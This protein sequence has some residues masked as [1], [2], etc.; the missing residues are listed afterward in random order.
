M[1]CILGS[2]Q[3]LLPKETGSKASGRLCPYSRELELQNHERVLE[4]L[5]VQP[6]QVTESGFL[7]SVVFYSQRYKAVWRPGKP[8][9]FDTKLFFLFKNPPSS[10]EKREPSCTVGGNVN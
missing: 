5:D 6:E 3:S 9:R 2:S 1:S 8:L 4:L 7:L 10:V